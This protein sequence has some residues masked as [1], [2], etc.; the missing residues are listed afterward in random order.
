[1]VLDTFQRAPISAGK[2]AK[3]IWGSVLKKPF[4]Q[5]QNEKPHC[6]DFQINKIQ[7]TKG[8]Y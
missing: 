4:D 3:V 6:D 2:H 8:N 7:K 1:M 5:Q